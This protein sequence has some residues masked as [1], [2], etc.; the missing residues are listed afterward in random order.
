MEQGHNGSSPI[1]VVRD[2]HKSFGDVHALAGVSLEIERG[3]V[4]GLLGPNGAGK[5]TLVRVL[6]TLLDP[7]EGSATV[8]GYDVRRE[9]TRV[10]P[11]IGLAGQSAAVDDTLTGRENLEMVA[12]LYHMGRAAAASRSTTCLGRKR[13]PS[14]MR[15]ASMMSPS[16]RSMPFRSLAG[17]VTWNFDL[18]VT[19]GM[20]S[21][22][23]Q[24]WNFRHSYRWAAPTARGRRAAAL[25]EARELAGGVSGGLAL[26]DRCADR[27]Q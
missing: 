4:L 13:I 27:G 8:A 19:R 10:R 6:T 24:S 12:N 22:R 15:V 3:T 20:G 11:L 5:T 7:D 16:R 23:G 9:R 17:M 21:S 1:V 2:V 14:P 26:S 25:A 18:T